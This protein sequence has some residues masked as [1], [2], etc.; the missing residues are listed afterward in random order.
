LIYN[1]IK[2]VS[3]NLDIL[4]ANFLLSKISETYKYFLWNEGDTTLKIFLNREL[5]SEEKLLLDE[6]AS[7]V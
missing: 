6:M 3:P 1:Y 4:E 2:Q 7:L 5:N